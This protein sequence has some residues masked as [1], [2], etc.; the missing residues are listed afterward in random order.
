MTTL[1]AQGI[2]YLSV[3]HRRP[4]GKLRE[5]NVE[6]YYAFNTVDKKIRKMLFRI[7]PSC[8]HQGRKRKALFNLSLIRKTWKKRILERTCV[9]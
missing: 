7:R 3:M 9:P 1:T 5:R 2:C 4:S 8:T 6:A